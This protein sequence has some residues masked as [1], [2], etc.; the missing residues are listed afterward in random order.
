METTVSPLGMLNPD[1]IESID[2]LKDASASAIY[3]SRGSAGVVI[4]T[5]KRGKAGQAKVTYDGYVGLQQQ[6]KFLKVDDLQQYAALENRLATA[7]GV[8]PRL[9]LQTRA[10]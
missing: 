8:Q 5:T 7:F 2:I 6:G 9:S 4:I 10:F 1:D 3:G